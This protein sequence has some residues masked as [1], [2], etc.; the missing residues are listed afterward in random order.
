MWALAYPLG[1]QEGLV[2]PPGFPDR[3]ASPDSLKQ[4]TLSIG[5]HSESWQKTE[6][7]PGVSSEG[8]LAQRLSVGCDQG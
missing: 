2:P 3:F 8:T 4:K 6:V 7:R 5:D 1:C